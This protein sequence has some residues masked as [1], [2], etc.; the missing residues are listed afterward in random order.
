MDKMVQ[1]S[2]FWQGYGGSLFSDIW[3][4][5]WVVHY[6]GSTH[7]LGRPENIVQ[8]EAYNGSFDLITIMC[9]IISLLRSISSCEFD[10]L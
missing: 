1:H 7:F 9:N 2:I 5:M 6:P 3:K 4:E 8:E 10:T